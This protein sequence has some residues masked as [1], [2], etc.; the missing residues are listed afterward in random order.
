MNKIQKLGK[1]NDQMTTKLSELYKKIEKLKDEEYLTND[2]ILT[3]FILPLAPTIVSMALLLITGSAVFAILLLISSF[4]GLITGNC[5]SNELKRLACKIHNIRISYLKKK[6]EKLTEKHYPLN[7]KFNAEKRKFCDAQKYVGSVLRYGN[8]QVVTNAEQAGV[9]GVE[10]DEKYVKQ[11]FS[12]QQKQ[13]PKVRK[14]VLETLKR[15]KKSKELLIEQEKLSKDYF[16][17]AIE[18]IINV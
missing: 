10:L 15:S 7:D 1:R 17:L 18:D 12:A 16:E 5:L 2:L 4:V 13:L 14:L 8:I 11:I 6:L 3:Q 9:K